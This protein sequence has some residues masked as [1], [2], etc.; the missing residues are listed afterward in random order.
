MS[1][2]SEEATITAP[3]FKTDGLSERKRKKKK[4]D[5]SL[6][7]T[8]IDN[9]TLYFVAGKSWVMSS[10]STNTNMSSR[11]NYYGSDFN[12]YSI[13]SDNKLHS[14]EIDRKIVTTFKKACNILL[15]NWNEKKYLMYLSSESIGTVQLYSL[16]LDKDFIKNEPVRYSLRPLFLPDFDNC[17]LFNSGELAFILY[18][19][20]MPKKHL[21]IQLVDE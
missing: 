10:L 8:Y 21:F 13:S 4:E 6:F 3:L 16:R 14:K 7:N 11:T 20:P 15:L 18:G 12:I 1:D 19:F 5:W 2:L 17:Y 9:D